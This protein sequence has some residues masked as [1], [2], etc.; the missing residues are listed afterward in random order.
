MFGWA[1]VLVAYL[2]EVLLFASKPVPVSAKRSDRGKFSRGKTITGPFEGKHL[3]QFLTLVS[4]FQKA[5][6]NGTVKKIMSGLI[7]LYKDRHQK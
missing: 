2:Q 6:P 5:G 3:Q 4:H 7:T 1:W